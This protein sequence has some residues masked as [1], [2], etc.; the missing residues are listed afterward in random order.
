MFAGPAVL[1]LYREPHSP[2]ID[3]TDSA[4]SLWLFHGGDL[5]CAEPHG[6]IIGGTMVS[7]GKKFIG[8]P[9]FVVLLLPWF[10]DTTGGFFIW[11]D[12][13]CMMVGAGKVSS[14]LTRGVVVPLIRRHH[15]AFHMVRLMMYND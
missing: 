10:S 6:W 5:L 12:Y 3:F 13:R 4:S 11:S 15:G 2:K 1:C 14:S 9:F 8:S 7:T